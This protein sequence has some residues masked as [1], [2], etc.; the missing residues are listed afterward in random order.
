MSTFTER[1]KRA[2]A[3][4]DYRQVDLSAATNISESKIS[5]YVSGRYMPNAES[6]IIIARVLSVNPEWLAGTSDVMEIPKGT[7]LM[8]KDASDLMA[9][10][11]R[12]DD[13][14]KGKLHGYADSLLAAEKYQ[15]GKESAG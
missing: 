9:K 1:L 2:M 12:L 4:R 13:L 10:Y 7:A 8:S 15:K 3:A 6:M 11:K 5:S 14:D